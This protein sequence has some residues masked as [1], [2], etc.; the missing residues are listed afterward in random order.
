MCVRGMPSNYIRIYILFDAAELWVSLCDCKSEHSLL[1]HMAV[2]QTQGTD[3]FQP[4]TN[5]AH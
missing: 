1:Y 3:R 4:S 5:G 2:R